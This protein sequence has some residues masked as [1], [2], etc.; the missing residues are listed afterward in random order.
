MYAAR[1]ASMPKSVPS[2]SS[3]LAVVLTAA[4]IARDV[5]TQRQSSR[6]HPQRTYTHHAL[7]S[8]NCV[9]KSLNVESSSW[10]FDTI[11]VEPMSA[12]MMIM[13]PIS[14]VNTV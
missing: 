3:S 13:I 1:L 11:V 9:M 14:E 8:S 5:H 12:G 6:A 10:W 7:L 2:A 4:E